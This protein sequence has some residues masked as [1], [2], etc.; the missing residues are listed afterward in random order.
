M[1]IKL[2]I[3]W[4]KKDYIVLTAE[5]YNYKFGEY[6]SYERRWLLTR[7]V[8]E[9][10]FNTYL[11][12][13]AGLHYVNEIKRIEKALNETTDESMIFGDLKIYSEKKIDDAFLM[14]LFGL[15][16]EQIRSENV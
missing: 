3:Y 7:Y 1:K 8:S 11:N 15:E 14:L 2:E 4:Q 5:G 9:R 6:W 16:E 13:P 10:I 12:S